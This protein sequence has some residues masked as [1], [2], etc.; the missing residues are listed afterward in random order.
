MIHDRFC[1]NRRYAAATGLAALYLQPGRQARP[2]GL[3]ILFQ[4]CIGL[5][6][7]R[8]PVSPGVLA[9]SPRTVMNHAG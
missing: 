5:S 7:L 6:G 9:V 4:V 1:C 8:V 3:T 2:R